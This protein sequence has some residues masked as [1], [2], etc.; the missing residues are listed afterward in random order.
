MNFEMSE[1]SSIN[2]MHLFHDFKDFLVLYATLFLNHQLLTFLFHQ[3]IS[4]LLSRCVRFYFY[5]RKI[6]FL[7]IPNGF[8]I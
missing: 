1:S 7:E 5:I 8:L 3:L 2:Y 4:E 6:N